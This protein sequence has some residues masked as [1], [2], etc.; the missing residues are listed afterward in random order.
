MVKTLDDQGCDSMNPAQNAEHQDTDAVLQL[1][2]LKQ[3][4]VAQLL[5]K[6]ARLW[7]ELA[8]ARLQQRF[9]QAR[10][11]HTSVLPHIDWEGTRI[12]AL[13]ARM[14]VTKQAASQLVQDMVR[15]GM[16]ELCPDPEDGRAKRVHFSAQGQQALGEGLQLLALMQQELAASMGQAKMAQ[17]LELLQTLVPLLED[18]QQ[19]QS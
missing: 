19:G 16:L 13:A 1:E 9:P 3:A 17:L 12:T 14:G 5:F 2:T 6:A 7:N 10:L 15:L 11:A 8:M 4:S 18:W